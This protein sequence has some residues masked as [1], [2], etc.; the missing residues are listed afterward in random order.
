MTSLALSFKPLELED[1]A[2]QKPVAVVQ[3]SKD[4]VEHIS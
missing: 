2:A 3:L 1:K 4:T